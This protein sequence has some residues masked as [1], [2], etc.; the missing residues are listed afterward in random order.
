MVVPLAAI[1][2]GWA[3]DTDWQK[4]TLAARRVVVLAKVDFKAVDERAI[5]S[6]YV[7]CRDV[8]K[9]NSIIVLPC[10]RVWCSL[11]DGWGSPSTGWDEI[12][13]RAT[14]LLPLHS[15]WNESSYMDII[16][17]HSLQRH[18]FFILLYTTQNKTKEEYKYCYPSTNRVQRSN[19]M[20]KIG[21]VLHP[22]PWTER[23]GDLV[24]FNQLLFMRKKPQISYQANLANEWK[25]EKEKKMQTNST[26]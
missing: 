2:K 18:R 15:N 25:T 23:A 7:W 17:G 6:N 9:K 11:M 14:I 20:L 19:L 16:N 1:Q 21:Q 13:Q 26:I 5:L 8:V 10:R 24:P 4:R 12:V 3:Y 22:V